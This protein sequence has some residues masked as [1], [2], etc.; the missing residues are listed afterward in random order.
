MKAEE[1]AA[2]RMRALLLELAGVKV[3]ATDPRVAELHRLAPQYPRG[4]RRATRVK[5][6]R[7][8]LADL[9]GEI[10]ANLAEAGIAAGARR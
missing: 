9:V 8:Q 6:I 10:D 1:V 2:L 5:R 3:P 7:N 4:W